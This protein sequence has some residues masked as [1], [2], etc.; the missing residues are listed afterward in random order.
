MS[1]NPYDE[2]K[3]KKK[4]FLRNKQ[5]AGLYIGDAPLTQGAKTA[6]FR[7][8]KFQQKAMDEAALR[9]GKDPKR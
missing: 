7:V 8:R 1:L 5:I 6:A 3:V 4:E 2:E 9:T